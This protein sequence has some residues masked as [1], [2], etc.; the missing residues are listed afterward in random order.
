MA[1]PAS[2]TLDPA[3]G[4]I[5]AADGFIAADSD[6]IALFPQQVVDNLM[7]AMV[8]LGAE[9]WTV[10][11]RMMILEKVLEK[12]GVSSEDLELYTPSA[13]EQASWAEE[14]TIYIAR[15]FGALARRGGANETQFKYSRME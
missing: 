14:R 5:S 9:L 1:G 7:H 15:T 10:R 8:A 12:T 2:Q 6:N 4:R 13:D 3:A 11:R